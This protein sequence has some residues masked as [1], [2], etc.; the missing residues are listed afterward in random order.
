MCLE[1]STSQGDIRQLTI[2]GEEEVCFNFET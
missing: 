2:S 1:N